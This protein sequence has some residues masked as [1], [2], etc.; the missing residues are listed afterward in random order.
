MYICP[1]VPESLSIIFIHFYLNVNTQKMCC[2]ST[3]NIFKCKIEDICG[4]DTL[5]KDAT[6][7][8]ILHTWLV[9]HEWHIHGYFV[10][11]NDLG[12]FTKNNSYSTWSQH[13]YKASPTL[14]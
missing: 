9:N 1:C 7:T 14:Y 8:L 5:G 6:V 2:F 13:V 10:F 12:F 11:Q 3:Q 4:T